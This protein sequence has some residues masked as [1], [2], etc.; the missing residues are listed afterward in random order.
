M[1]GAA[2]VTLALDADA[3]AA[4]R[5]LHE[6]LETYYAAPA[7]VILARQACYAG[8]ATGLAEWLAGYSRAGATHLVLRFAGDHERHMDTVAGLRTQ[9]G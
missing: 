8:G 2:Y 9:L 7:R 5:R 3:A 4:E 6:F 1:T